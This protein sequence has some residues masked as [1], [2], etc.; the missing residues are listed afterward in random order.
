MVKP[1]TPRGDIPG[2]YSL[3]ASGDRKAKDDLLAIYENYIRVVIQNMKSKHGLRMEI[4]D[5]VQDGRTGLLRSL[6]SLSLSKDY[7][8]YASWIEWHI[9][10]EIMSAVLREMRTPDSD[11]APHEL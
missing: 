8:T 5:L 10:R 9:D 2:L 3:A 6:T 11:R 1:E 4:A 7:P